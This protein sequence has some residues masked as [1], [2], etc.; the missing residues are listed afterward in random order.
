MGPKLD[1]TIWN[2]LM[3]LAL[4]ALSNT[5]FDHCKIKIR[6][7]RTFHLGLRKSWKSMEG[8]SCRSSGRVVW[9][10]LLFPRVDLVRV[11]TAWIAYSLQHRLP[12]KTGGTHSTLSEELNIRKDWEI[13]PIWLPRLSLLLCF[14]SILYQDFV[15]KDEARREVRKGTRGFGRGQEWKE[16]DKI[17][18]GQALHTLHITLYVTYPVPVL[19]DCGF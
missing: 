8:S 6:K 17:G 9:E 14:L 12:S 7:S 11:V 15:A 1:S 2:P 18:L 5:V 19:E 10:E 13:N 3:Y 4:V 16:G